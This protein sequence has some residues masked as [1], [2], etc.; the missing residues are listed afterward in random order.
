LL[1]PE[2]IV[3]VT[4]TFDQKVDHSRLLIV[5]SSGFVL[6]CDEDELKSITIDRIKEP[7]LH[8]N[9]HLQK[10]VEKAVRNVIYTETRRRPLV[11]VSVNELE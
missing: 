1:S 3:K 2:G 4:L 9:R 8:A 7:N 10:D 5:I 11:L 6:N